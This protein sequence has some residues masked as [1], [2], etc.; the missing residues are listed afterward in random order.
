MA[1][2]DS[3]DEFESIEDELKECLRELS[4][5]ES[6]TN[7]DVKS[8]PDQASEQSSQPENCIETISKNVEEQ[9]LNTSDL[10]T[11]RS[12]LAKERIAKWKRE[13]HQRIVEKDLL[14]EKTKKLWREKAAED[15]ERFMKNRLDSLRKPEIEDYPDTCETGGVGDIQGENVWARVAKICDFDSQPRCSKNVLRMRDVIISLSDARP[16]ADGSL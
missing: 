7:V 1:K 13:F 12:D 2:F 3:K 9:Q 15:L 10:P 16:P 8:S 6:S 14:E 4:A 11:G 5:E